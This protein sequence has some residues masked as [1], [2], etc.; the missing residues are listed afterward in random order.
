MAFWLEKFERNI[1]RDRSNCSA[2]KQLG[3]KVLIVWECELREMEKVIRRLKK[4][5]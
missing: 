5:L 4:S 3:W 1:A 2:L